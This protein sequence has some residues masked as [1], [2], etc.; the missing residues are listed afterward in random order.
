MIKLKQ[1]YYNIITTQIMFIASLNI[2]HTMFIASMKL[3]RISA[4]YK[5]H[6]TRMQ[7]NTKYDS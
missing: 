2:V 4:L 1:V 5:L 6:I 7:C 3:F